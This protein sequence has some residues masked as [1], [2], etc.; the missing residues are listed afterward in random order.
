MR[1][2]IAALTGAYLLIT[3]SALAQA[4]LMPYPSYYGV[5]RGDEQT[6]Q[7]EP[8]HVTFFEF[9]QI[10]RVCSYNHID[11]H[12]AMDNG[13]VRTEYS[14]LL[15]CET[16]SAIRNERSINRLQFLNHGDRTA[17]IGGTTYHRQE[18]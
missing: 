14:F 13:A 3:T 1:R 16:F 4:P 11:T 9:G 12:P 15:Q 5:W 8:G 7:I 2:S 18:R 17:T 10:D 6:I